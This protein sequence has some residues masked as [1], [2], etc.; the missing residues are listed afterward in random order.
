VVGVAPSGFAF[1][2]RDARL[3]TP[4]VMPRREEAEDGSI[5]VFS[6]LALSHGLRRQ[7]ELA[8]RAVLGASRGRLARQ[9]LT[10][11]LLVALLGGA[12]G[13]LL[14][15]GITR[16]L[17]ALAPNG[18]PRI[19][20]VRIDGRV[21]AFAL[22][23]SVLSGIL[24]GVLPALRGA[25]TGLSPALHDGG[26]RAT[27]G[28]AG[29]L[30]H[31]LLVGE[32]ALAVVLL[33]GAGLLVR[34]FARLIQV[35][36]G[37][38]PAH[39]LMA[40]ICFPE[41]S[42]QEGRRQAIDALL[43]RLRGTPGV[44]VAA[45]GNMPPFAS[46]TALATAPLPWR[47]ADS[48][49]V[50]ARVLIHGVTA[51]YPEALGLRLREGRVL[52]PKGSGRSPRA[53]LV[54]EEFVR[55]YVRDGRSVVGRQLEGF[56][57]E[58]KTMTE[59]VGV[60]GNVLKDGLD[61]RPQPE[62]YVADVSEVPTEVSLV[63]RTNGEPL[64]IA[65]LL[66]RLVREIDPRVATDGIATL[67]ERVSASVAEP[68]FA[69]IVLVA[70]AALALGLAATGL[71]GVLSYSVSHRRREIGIRGALGARRSDLLSLVLRQGLTLTLGG[72]AL[73]LLAAALV[74]RLLAGLLFGVTPLD[75]AAF[76][77]APALLLPIAALA[78]LIPARR[79]AS[80]DPAE[81]L[82]SE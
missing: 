57:S 22:V 61:A 67:A 17:P 42:T 49:P 68:R 9:L 14:A 39:V 64:T 48:Q 35:D 29:G 55:A 19:D 77:A 72:L 65:P 21:L 43:D 81:A 80:V 66:P 32:A 50:M 7:R 23:V 28:H 63:V 5:R 10:E 52:T 51:G 30:G 58:E 71:Y 75:P 36:A 41:G 24:A 74:T 60:V 45:T 18:F 16:A 8:V 33:V 59:I 62:V 69:A 46:M 78:C 2:D 47:G 56:L 73:G 26:L 31:S 6:A 34:S 37:Y 79:A 44:A 3:W 27:G 76:A 82:R 53:M 1:P 15:W 20:D 25:R 13:L 4:Y 12:L 11:S 38:D 40:Q 54:N 70:F